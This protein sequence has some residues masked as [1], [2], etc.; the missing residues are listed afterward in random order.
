MDNL[1]PL[2][3]VH[4]YENKGSIFAAMQRYGYK[5]I[6]VLIDAKHFC[7]YRAS[8]DNKQKTVL[9]KQYKGIAEQINLASLQHENLILNQ[10][11]LSSILI[12]YDLI[13]EGDD[14]LVVAEDVK[15]STL[16]YF[17]KNN[18][19]ALNEFFNVALQT[20]EAII[21]L[22]LQHVSHSCISYRN[23]FIQPSSLRLKLLEPGLNLPQQK[24]DD[25]SELRAFGNLF[26]QLLT[27]E[28]N[29]KI[30]KL[31]NVPTQIKALIS[32]CQTEIE[33]EAYHNLAGLKADL[34]ECQSQW[35]NKKEID[36]FVLGQQENGDNFSLSQ[37]LYGRELQ[38]SSILEMFERVCRN[39][40]ELLLISGYSGIGK[41]SLVRE[42]Y[43]PVSQQQGYFINGK[44]DQ[45]NKVTP[46]SAFIEAF[47]VLVQKL[48]T[49]PEDYLQDLKRALQKE[50]GTNAQIILNVIPSMSILLG[51]QKGVG[52]VSHAEAQ[53]RFIF[54]L[55]SF[56]R[57][58]AQKNHPLVVFLDDLQ[59]IDSAS[60]RLM[61]ALLS[62]KEIHHFLL[63]GAYRDNEV[64][65]DHPLS[66][67]LE[68]IK[69]SQ[70]VINTIT[71]SPLERN[72]I[73]HLL[74]D[75]FNCNVE[76]TEKLADILLRKTNGNPFFINQFI[77]LLYQKKLLGFNFA[78]RRW[79]WDTE[80]I[81]KQPIT[82][83]VVDLLLYRIK[84]LPE[85]TQKIL[86]L[87]A[88]IGHKFDL[89]TLS[90][91]S[92]LSTIQTI[93]YLYE[94]IIVNLV[95]PQAG[96][97]K[98][99]SIIETMALADVLNPANLCYQFVHDKIQ[100]AAYSLIPEDVRAQVHLQIGRLLLKQKYPRENDED[101]F[102]I[103]NHFITSLELINDD[104]ERI[105]LAKLFLWAGQRAKGST[106]YVAAK[107]YFQAGIRLLNALHSA[108]DKVL[109]FELDKGLAVCLYLTGDFTGAEAKFDYLLRYAQDVLD[110]V[111]IYQ[112]H[113]EML[114]TLNKH[115]ES[116]QK[117]IEGLHLL[118]VHLTNKP[119]LFHILKAILTIKYL[120]RGRNPQQVEL[121]AMSN[122]KIEAA[123]D[124]ISQLFNSAF[125]VN[126][127][128]FLV[129]ACTNVALSLR[130]GYSES[131][132][133]ACLVYAFIILHAKGW[134]KQAMDFVN[135]YF[136]L[137]EMMLTPR[138]SGK[139]IFV[140]ACFIYP[141][142]NT[143]E[144]A[145]SVL[146]Q[147]Y[148]V[149]YEA[150][151]LAYA[152]YS[153]LLLVQ[154]CFFAGVPF[155]EVETY[156]TKS[157]NFLEKTKTND[158]SELIQF[159][160]FSM[161]CMAGQAYTPE[162]IF[163][164]EKKITDTLNVTGLAFF[165]C[166]A[167]KLLY[168]TDAF[169]A[170]ETYAKKFEK[171]AN[172][173]IGMVAA[174][175]GEFYRGMALMRKVQNKKQLSVGE[176][177][178]L[179]RILK[180]LKQLSSWNAKNFEHYYGLF[181]AELERL[182]DNNLE[183]IRHYNTAIQIA[184]TQTSTCIV[185]MA[186]ECACMFY[187]QAAL[188]ELVKM[189]AHKAYVAYQHLGALAK[190]Q[191]LKQHF[192]E[193]MENIIDIPSE[194]VMAPQQKTTLSQL[195]SVDI[196]FILQATQSLSS[197]IRL[198]SLLKKLLY[199]LLQVTQ[200]QHGFILMKEGNEWYVE[201]E[202]SI[203]LQRTYLNDLQRVSERPDIPLSLIE[204]VENS[205][206]IL[207]L[208]DQNDKRPHA[209]EEYLK[210]MLPNSL[211]V[212][213][214]FFRDK[215]RSIF[216]IENKNRANAFTTNHVETVQLL[217]SQ[218][219]IS[220]ENAQLYY[221]AT[222]DLI[223]GLANRNLFYQ[224]FNQ[225]I[226]KAKRSDGLLA[227]IFLDIDD[228]KKINN[229]MGQEVGD[230][231]L[232]YCAQ[233]VKECLRSGDIVAR[234]GSDEFIIV[235]EDVLDVD[236]VNGIAK[237]VLER[238]AN[239][240]HI[241]DH[242]IR[243]SVSMGISMYPNNSSDSQVLTKQAEMA[244]Y[245]V[246][247]TNKGSFQFYT[248]ELNEA[249]RKESARE[250]ELIDAFKKREFSVFYQPIFSSKTHQLT[251]F[252]ALL[253]WHHPQ[254]G[255]VPAKHFMV[256]VE[257]S[258]LIADIGDWVI[259]TVFN[260]LRLWKEKGINIVPVAINISASQFK[261]YDLAQMIL[262]YANQFKIEPTFIELE[263]TE[264]ILIERAKY[265]MEQIRALKALNLKMSIDDFG[266][267]YSSLTYLKQL[268]IDALKVDKSFVM[269]IIENQDS[270]AIVLAI[271]AMAHNLHLQVVAEG[272]ENK[273]QLRYLEKIGVDEVQ[274][275]FFGRPSSSDVC[276]KYFYDNYIKG[277]L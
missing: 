146:H 21:A 168:L 14:L 259:K 207:V 238:F 148:H 160:H 64:D 193:G 240:I 274:G 196:L 12:T 227:L 48:L 1:N 103:V 226:V 252:E 208:Q 141:Y 35:T 201:A 82:D 90:T 192:S 128:L 178:I 276:V 109:A 205:H 247:S 30:D 9:I 133:F 111:S 218:A 70:M 100:Q 222:H 159:Y 92:E 175:E 195:D 41:T 96:S 37:K 203:N 71:L 59:W 24:S 204:Y 171:I 230:K 229:L 99:S 54:T 121:T 83:N 261:H 186:N 84:Q 149:A 62:D 108:E 157:L 255:L 101:L 158:F 38:V 67:A 79:D 194:T 36:S 199:L 249:L 211:I 88:C 107:K 120:L 126:Q 223:T 206:K 187:L 17:I 80:V 152:N 87:A 266:T 60:L 253:R 188:P 184:Q 18:P 72:D 217:A 215:L 122:V 161:Q 236:E 28:I 216:Y 212:L 197:E 27:G 102:D 224:L 209:K 258:D 94:A 173:A 180:K 219:A 26:L 31:S 22:Q 75:S 248:P 142:S 225:A 43:K 191:A 33:T 185:A 3:L 50:L 145:I 106:A 273:E 110:K 155:S 234:M 68:Q 202:G 239:T 214:V 268:P 263:F 139:N 77:K 162:E 113:C 137:N 176:K 232:A 51:E 91:I 275:F 143:S 277:I 228:F 127:N 39:S 233:Q 131:T 138:F 221:Q 25:K 220:L 58:L 7:I 271:V 244:L 153:N 6:E 98:V 256:A 172:Y 63:I 241:F 237:H 177:H 4:N 154:H 104:N 73:E 134:Y 166:V 254:H 125:I 151:D 213:P 246:K 132:T 45:L 136:K 86:Q 129:L 47:N 57:V 15:W 42:L 231:V 32:K 97:N 61:Q 150:G 140:L 81:S 156:V 55:Q 5:I 66:L 130:Y 123:M 210:S 272:I 65:A 144:H 8:A 251:H 52:K 114:A 2:Y 93:Q 112:L 117:G 190:C 164:W 46:Y 56:I 13:I 118:G 181:Q 243:L 264:T 163:Q 20:L 116:I 19:L 119:N 89:L 169:V 262:N 183:A 74:A 245:R 11:T 105:F 198:G 235:L 189:H 95:I 78:T 200:A 76:E 10:L 69:K 34:L 179:K 49:E 250:L 270:Q 44:F 257:K 167:M 174:V 115:N 124:L 135:L 23:L 147:A 53:N 265:V 29:A 85:Q 165:Y 242:D 267:Y 260:Q 16:G 182:Q 269:D 170:V 40:T